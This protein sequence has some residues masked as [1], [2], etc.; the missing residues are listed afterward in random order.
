MDYPITSAIRF[1]RE[2]NISFTPH[3]Y[4]YEENGGTRASAVA[5][6][7]D[8]HTVVKTLVM[9]TNERKPLLVLMHG[10]REVSTK[11]LARILGMKTVEPCD[12]ASAQKYTGYLFGGTSPFGT[13]TNLPVFVESSIFSLPKIYING[14]KRGFLVE[15]NP[16]NLRILLNVQEVFVSIESQARF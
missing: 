3:L 5:L 12:A 4:T 14:G 9:Q 16:D 8:E 13:R 1:L 11:Q 2:K 10:D 6:H 15:I 7:V